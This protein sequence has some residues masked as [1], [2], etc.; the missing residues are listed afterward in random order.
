MTRPTKVEPGVTLRQFF[1]KMLAELGP[2]D[3]WPAR[4]RL[5][6]ILGAILVQN[7]AWQNAA[8]ALK[9]LRQKGLLNLA[10][11]RGAF[12][13]E[14]ESCVRPA[15]FFRQ[16][17]RTIQNFLTWLE[18]NCHGSLAT[19]FSLKTELARQQLLAIKG[20][21]PET[22]DAILLYAGHR[23]VFVADN[24]TRRILARHEMVMPAA[25][26]A[27]VQQFLHQHLPSDPDLYNEYHALLVEVGK[28]YCK[29]TDPLCDECPLQKFLGH[30][31]PNLPI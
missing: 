28:K 18:R 21:G 13:A 30:H 23:P 14:L 5:E 20:L 3:W 2:Q 1:A 10:R 22:V 24:Y 8:L 29:R 17:T 31:R 7:T 26:Y 27:E 12:R 11:L 15:G 16:K 9:Q 25:D 6:I 19:M 4:T